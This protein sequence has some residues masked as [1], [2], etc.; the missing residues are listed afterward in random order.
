MEI[1]PLGDSALIVRVRDEFE[2]N[3]EETLNAVLAA[4][5]R[6]E[7]A[8]LPGAIEL[9][10][11]YTTVAFFYNPAAAAEAG[12]P[13]ED[14]FG[15]YAKQIRVA[16]S[17]VAGVGKPGR[18]Q[19]QRMLSIEI[20]VCYADEFA[21]DLNDVAQQ[22]G[23]SAPEF[24]DLHCGARYRVHCVG[25]I[26]GFP[27]LGG[28][29]A[30][31]ATPRRSTPRTEIPAGSVG[32]GGAQTGIYPVKS[33]GGWNVIGRT[34]LRLFDPEKNPPTLLLAGNRVRFRPIGRDEFDAL[35]GGSR[36]PSA[37]VKRRANGALNS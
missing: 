35:A 11:G 20:P 31:L 24:V 1:T 12:A 7:A 33:P 5:Q 10:P 28:L 19:R 17:S 29:P 2:S 22:A 16:L 8:R 15:W 3:P 30:R 14:I 13:A 4:Q 23:I 32:I 9:A 36:A 25:F 37:M 18:G 21:P 27:F 26:A 6:L 34:P